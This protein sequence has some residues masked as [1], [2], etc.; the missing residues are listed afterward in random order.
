MIFITRYLK[1]SDT[2]FLL[3]TRENVVFDT[4]AKKAISIIVVNLFILQEAR[5]KADTN[6]WTKVIINRAMSPT[7]VGDMIFSCI[8]SH[9]PR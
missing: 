7:L 6:N 2:C 5:V 3:I 1:T 8:L 4:P 9:D